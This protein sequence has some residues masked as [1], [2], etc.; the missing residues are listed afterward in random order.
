M[1]SLV[2]VLTAA[3]YAFFAWESG[4]W[5]AEQAIMAAIPAFQ[6]IIVSSMY[7]LFV[8]SLDRD[9]VNVALNFEVGLAWDRV[10]VLFTVVISYLVP[11]NII[12]AFG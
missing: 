2:V 4:T 6:M 12:W 3:S 5:S 7:H 8:R 1:P 11:A 9:P 10:F